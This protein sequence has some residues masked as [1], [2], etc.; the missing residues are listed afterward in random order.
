MS[1]QVEHQLVGKKIVGID[2]ADDQMAVRFRLSGGEEIVAKCDADCCSQTYIEDINLPVQG[3][4]AIVLSVD[5]VDFLDK[6]VQT[7]GDVTQF[8]ACKIATTSG[9]IL[10]EYRN[11]SN[12]YYGGSLAWPGDSFYGGVHGQNISEMVWVPLEDVKGGGA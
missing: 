3:L 8:Y 12:G 1:E 6:E 7:D 5:N 2:L 10:I 9:E 11:G 4:P